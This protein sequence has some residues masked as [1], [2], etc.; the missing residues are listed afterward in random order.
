MKR[1]Y[2]L[3]IVLL[4]ILSLK[5]QQSLPQILS[6]IESNNKTL[7]AAKQSAQV[8]KIDAKTGIYPSDINVEYE[9]MFG[10]D[11]TN[12]QRESELTVTQDFDFPTAYFKKNK[13]AN[14]KS[15]QADI[16]YKVNRQNILLEAKLV[17][18]ELVFYNKIKLILN[19]RLSNAESLNKSYKKRLELGDAN[20]LETN[21]IALELLNVQT[22]YRL[23][24]VEISNRLQK[25][26][27]L[28]GG[29]TI[30]FTDTVYADA[31]AMYAMD[32]IVQ[33]S[34]ANNPE[35]KVLEQEKNIASKS[36]GLAKSLYLPKIT[37]GYKMNISNPEKFHGFVAG[38]SIP[39][40]ENKNT[41]KRAKA[42][43]V[44]TE[45]E[46]DNTR[47]MQTNSIAQLYDKVSALKTSSDEYRSL[48]ST[49]NNN[50]LLL[51]ALNLGQISLLEYL[52]EVNFLYQSTESY[53]QTEKDYY[54]SLAELLKYNL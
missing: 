21:K 36:I 18:V 11:A 15:E 33:Q 16:Q 46:I 5:A 9:Y 54:S 28:N 51:K 48:L 27:E 19:N 29:I 52:T 45:L 22:E 24:E 39:M 6:D 25:L 47:L 38:I 2:I 7:K 31:Q 4:G 32:N 1:I 35:L 53:L 44:L 14:L 23:N 43:T 41:V 20:A 30:A 34:L 10:N 8:Q 49:Q 37:I 3:S 13:I 42:Q 26:A 50:H 17:C 12:Y 40:W